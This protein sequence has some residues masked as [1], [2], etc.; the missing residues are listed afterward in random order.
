[1]K[2]EERAGKEKAVKIDETIESKLSVQV[3]LNSLPLSPLPPSLHRS[4]QAFQAYQAPV[5][6]QF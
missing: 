3:T 4:F 5:S 2:K 1:M 6:V